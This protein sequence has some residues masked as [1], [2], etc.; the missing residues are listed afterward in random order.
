MGRAPILL[1]LLTAAAAVAA[2]G[3]AA[4]AA[5][6]LPP[7]PFNVVWDVPAQGC[8]HRNIS[9]PL[10]RFLVVTNGGDDTAFDGGNITLFYKVGLWPQLLPDNKTVNGGIPQLGNLSAHLA[11]VAVDVQAQMP[12]AT[13]AAVAIIDWEAWRV[14]YELNYDALSPY[15]TASQQLVRRQ[16]PDWTN[17]TQIGIQAKKD[18]D[19]AARAFFEQTLATCKALRP[20]ARWGYYEYPLCAADIEG[21]HCNNAAANDGL[22]WLW[23]ATD[24]LSPSIY[25]YNQDTPL[26]NWTRTVLVKVAEAVRVAPAGAAV[27]PFGTLWTKQHFANGSSASVFLDPPHLAVQL[28]SVAQT[29]ADGVIIWGS[30]ANSGAC[31]NIRAYIESNFGPMAQSLTANRTV[32]ATQVCSGHGRCIDPAVPP[33][34]PPDHAA[35]RQA[36]CRCTAPWTG[37]ACSKSEFPL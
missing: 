24:V 7:R 27:L 1:A 25:Q 11:Q 23:K 26:G 19:C 34:S 12:N 8:H 28:E 17:E 36:S 37:P 10:E 13:S 33:L 22:D 6:A 4:S 14:T 30:S 35:A 29:G 2:A 15:R 16:H 32:C 31:E 20:Q 9:F 3:L 18:F 21:M 5:A